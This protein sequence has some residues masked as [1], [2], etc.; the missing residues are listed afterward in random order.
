MRVHRKGKNEDGEDH[1][2]YI[3]DGGSERLLAELRSLYDD[4]LPFPMS[5]QVYRYITRLKTKE[6]LKHFYLGLQVGI[7]MNKI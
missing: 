6:D 5:V 1:F 2:L 7:E 4:D 3:L